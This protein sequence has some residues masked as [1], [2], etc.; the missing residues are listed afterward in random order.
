MR[1]TTIFQA[2]AVL[3][4]LALIGVSC[5]SGSNETAEQLQVVEQQLAEVTAERDVLQAQIDRQTDRYDKST[6]VRLAVRDILDN[7]ETYGTEAEVVELLASYATPDAVMQDDTFDAWVDMRTSW[8]NTLYR[9][10]MDATIEQLHEWMSDDG[11]QSS[12]LWIWKGKNQSGNDFELIGVAIDS[13]N[14][15]GLITHETVLYPYPDSY[16]WNAV[17]AAGNVNPSSN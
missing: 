14:E 16:V 4:L 15:E 11:S 7:P 6:A 13:H 1:S 17:V 3:L 8:Q 5:S 10:A 9:G 2:A 12:S